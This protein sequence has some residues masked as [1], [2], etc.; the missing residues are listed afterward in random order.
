[1]IMLLG[2]AQAMSLEQVV[3]RAAEVNPFGV[4]AELQRK[5]GSLE[6]AEGWTALGPTAQLGYQRRLTAGVWSGGASWS[7]SLGAL[8]PGAWANA[9]QQ[10]AQAKE[11]GVIADATVLDA[12]Y[13]AAYLYYDLLAAQAASE[14][15]EQ[16][17]KAA[18]ATLDASK[19][20]V[21]AGLES[22]LSG[23]SA[24]VELLRAAADREKAGATQRIAKARLERA[25]EQTVDGVQA[26]G[27]LELPA[28]MDPLWLKVAAASRESAR[29]A[30]IEG[31]ADLFPA[32][33]LSVGQPAG[34]PNLTL[35]VGVTWTFDGIAGPF[36]RERGLA[37]ESR[38][39]QVQYEALRRDLD[40]G[41]V[42]AKEQARAA[43]AVA[44]AARAR[45]ELATATLEVGQARLTAGLASV[46]EVLRLQDDVVEA[47]ADRI[48]AE[49]GEAYALLSARQVAG[50]GWGN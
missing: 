34:S 28:E 6:A 23:R 45:E 1:M 26:P 47:R 21:Q 38:I 2:L 44:E 14:A 12:Q 30:H 29:W 10:R 4:V 18:Q 33:N 50:V 7:L 35:S 41:L 49:R 39:A 42:E 20:R 8:D 46:L 17:Y 19:A 25:L 3:A 40:L 36:L 5:V 22:E 37:L 43:R 27:P 9:G 16:S 48:D 24:E 31:I 32:G 11:A 15:T 13:A